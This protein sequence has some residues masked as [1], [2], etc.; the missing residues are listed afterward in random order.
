[1]NDISDVL[2]SL[3]FTAD[4]IDTLYLNERRVSEHFI[5]NLGAIESLIRSVSSG[6]SGGTDLKIVQGE[7]SAQQSAQVTWNLQSPIAK[8]LVLRA[9]LTEKRNAFQ[10]PDE[11]S[12]G[13]YV[14]I[15]GIGYVTAADYEVDSMRELIDPIEEGLYDQIESARSSREKWKKKSDPTSE[16]F[17]L[18]LL[19]DER[20]RVCVTFLDSRGLS[21][22]SEHWALP[23]EVFG[24]VR[25][26]IGTALRVRCIHSYLRWS[27]HQ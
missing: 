26:R 13:D 27:A 14:L 16:Q 1:M 19:R 17:T 8:A 15:S 25:E 12:E 5:I 2:N 23:T 6:K 11:A 3:T 9:A 24:A 22:D 7:V 20:P 10:E 21:L 18:T 4:P